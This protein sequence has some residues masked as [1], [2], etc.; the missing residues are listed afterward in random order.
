MKAL[1]LGVE[2]KDTVS[3]TKGILT[4]LIINM[5][6]GKEYIFQPGLL[7]PETGK[8]VEAILV[9]EA[10]IKGGV[11]EKVDIPLEIMGEKGIDKAT[12]FKGTIA[13]IYLHINGCVHVSLKPKGTNKTTGDTLD[14]VEFDIRR[15]ECEKLTELTEAELKKSLKTK[16]S[17]LAISSKIKI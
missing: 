2:V 14:A 3:G 5:S 1:K 7:S 13:K 11:K 15:I 12:K 4:H 10:R 16:P 9:D 6:F 8:P 17:P